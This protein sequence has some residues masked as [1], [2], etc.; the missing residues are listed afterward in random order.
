M[1]KDLLNFT[2]QFL[3]LVTD[4]GFGTGLQFTLGNHTEY[5]TTY[6]YMLGWEG[7]PHR[8]ILDEWWGEFLSQACLLVF[9]ILVGFRYL[10]LC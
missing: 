7:W 6:Q 10:L 9:R 8:A 1:L 2:S 4:V 5:N 3:Q